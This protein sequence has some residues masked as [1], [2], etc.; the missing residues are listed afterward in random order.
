MTTNRNSNVEWLTTGYPSKV[1]D[2]T[3][4]SNSEPPHPSGRGRQVHNYLRASHSSNLAT[5]WFT[6][7]TTDPATSSPVK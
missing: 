2:L 6:L 3:I 4:L 7:E 1:T 5:G